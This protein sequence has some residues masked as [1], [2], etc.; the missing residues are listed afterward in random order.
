MKA[1]P[2]NPVTLP[3]FWVS[4]VQLCLDHIWKEPNG[5]WTVLFL[6]NLLKILELFLKIKNI[7]K[8]TKIST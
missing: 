6:T 7:L 1:F 2:L 8:L 3:Q 4:W 5:Q